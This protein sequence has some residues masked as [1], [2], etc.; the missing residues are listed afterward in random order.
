MRMPLLVAVALLWLPRAWSGTPYVNH[1][2]GFGT[3]TIVKDGLVLTVYHAL[4]PGLKV[5]GQPTEVVAKNEE[6]DLLLVK[7]PVKGKV[8]F[9]KAYIDEEV[10][11]VGYGFALKMVVRGR[12][13]V[14]EDKGCHFLIDART[15]QGSS[16]S[17]IYNLTGEM[18]GMI[19]AIKK[20]DHG[21][22]LA[23]GVTSQVLKPFVEGKGDYREPLRADSQSQA[24]R[25]VQEAP[26]LHWLRGVQAQR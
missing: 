22:I 10:V 9:A 11:I 8:R 16:G 15:P 3:G 19:V 18:V 12:V 13:A 5:N 25:G 7:A 20:D 4:A 21:T 1:D 26:R 23:I 14:V 2:K 6:Y 24:A 17:G